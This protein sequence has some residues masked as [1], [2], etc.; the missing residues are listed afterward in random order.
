M[1]HLSRWVLMWWIF[2]LAA[3][4]ARSPLR[5]DSFGVPLDGTV[6]LPDASDGGSL[7]PGTDRVDMLLVID[8]SGSMTEVQTLL[9]LKFES[10][11]Q[12]LRFPPCV[13][14][15][16]PNIEPHACDVN[17]TDDVPIH[18][19]LRDLQLGVV[20]TDL[21]TPGSM[22]PGCDDSERGDHGLLNPI[23]NG[24]ALQMHLPWAPRRPNAVVAPPG[25]RPAAC[26]NDP[27]QFPSF[28]RFCSNL[29]DPSCDGVEP[30]RSTRSD[31]TF[32]DWF[33][34][35]AG[36]FI[37][38]C[39]LEQP[40]EAAWRA[41]FFH[42]ARAIAGNSSPNAGFIRDDALLVIVVVSDEEDGSVRNCDYDFG[43]SQQSGGSCSD[44]RDVYTLSSPAW[45]H[46]TNLDLRFYLYEPG[47]PRDPNW[48]LDRYINT[49]PRTTPNRWTRDFLS[50]KPGRPD[51]VVFAAITGVP[52]E[53]PRRG[54][55]IDYDALLGR[56]SASPDDFYR[57][58]SS[59][60]ISGTQGP[61]GPFSMRHA[62][63]SSECGHMVPACRRQGTTYNPM[64]PCSNT[65]YQAFPSRRIVE[66]ARRFEESP[67]CAGAP[68][69]NGLVTS[70]CAASLDN[71][72]N[73]LA[74]KLA[75][76]MER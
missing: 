44:A 31:T 64:Q 3:C 25:F 29:A 42:D 52:L 7:G 48:N 75:A 66:V 16:N 76:R 27:N 45:A 65:Q 11:L 46:P 19:P 30:N 58:D 40:L 63:M 60:A 72:L 17:N 69:R 71:A 21:G 37:N 39:G 2:A 73:Q 14:R 23:R 62:N 1:R 74:A 70:I 18:R 4:G 54:A 68:C 38:G 26:N 13:S 56:P 51:R 10:L 28:I 6:T 8:N 59:T 36:L 22:V 24:P 33:K 49:A 32:S 41:L 50:L 57:R 53:V 43:F 5:V 67:L 15:S 12:T 9:L 20:S 34:C 47:G 61:S 55:A 35:N